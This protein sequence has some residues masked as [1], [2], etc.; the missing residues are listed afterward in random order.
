MSEIFDHRLLVK[1]AAR[2]RTGAQ[3]QLALDTVLNMCEDLECPECARIIC[4]HKDDMHFHHDGCPSCS[5]DQD[6]LGAP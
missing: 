6:L 5:T 4:P 2:A 3:D 1:A